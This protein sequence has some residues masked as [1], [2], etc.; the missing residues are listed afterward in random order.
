MS[1]V[2]W[3]HLAGRVL[4]QAPTKTLR[5][6]SGTGRCAAATKPGDRIHCTDP[7]GTYHESL[8]LGA[9]SRAQLRRDNELGAKKRPASRALI[10]AHRPR[11]LANGS[12]HRD[13]GNGLPSRCFHETTDK[14][15]S[16]AP[17]LERKLAWRHATLAQALSNGLNFTRRP[18]STTSSR[19]S[20]KFAPLT[21]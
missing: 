21:P 8:A 1:H 20:N 4:R 14:K 12:N 19:P 17:C 11:Q 15:K 3:C 10:S 6:S 2:G 7:L 13:R 18:Q 9:D 16:F 5:E